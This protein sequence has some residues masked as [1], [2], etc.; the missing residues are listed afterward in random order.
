MSLDENT[1]IEYTVEDKNGERVI[2]TFTLQQVEGSVPNFY[3]AF[4]KSLEDL[5]DFD[6]E[7]SEIVSRRIVSD[8]NEESL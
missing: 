7:N 8:S 5:E 1:L 6:L 2:A 4:K 3:E